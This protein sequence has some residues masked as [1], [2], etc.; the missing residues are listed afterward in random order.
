M[1]LAIIPLKHESLPGGNVFNTLH[2]Y[3]EVPDYVLEFWA[4]GAKTEYVDEETYLKQVH[5]LQ[6]SQQE[7]IKQFWRENAL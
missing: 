3:W 2:G 1:K 4:S 5:E 6:E 7:C